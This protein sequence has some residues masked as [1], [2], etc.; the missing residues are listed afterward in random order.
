MERKTEEMRESLTSSS[1]HI[2]IL[3]QKTYKYELEN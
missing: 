3:E 2:R 1:S